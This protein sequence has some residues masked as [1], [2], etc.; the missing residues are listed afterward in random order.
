MRL[1]HRSLF[2]VEKLARQSERDVFFDAVEIGHDYVEHVAEPVTQR[3]DKL[4]R[5]ADAPAVIPTVC[6]PSSQAE[7][8]LPASG[9]R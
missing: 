5:G 3:L 1:S 8:R 9:I 7:S 2:S 6:A 4:F